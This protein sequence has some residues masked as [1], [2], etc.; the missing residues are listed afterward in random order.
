MKID[1]NL[2][3]TIASAVAEAVAVDR[4]G[5]IIKTQV[6]KAV[7]DA[8]QS[9]FNYHSP[10]RK[11]LEKSVAEMMPHALELD[12]QADW[13]H[14]VTHSINQRLSEVNDDRFKQ[15][16]LPVLDKLLEPAPASVKLSQLLKSI[17]DYWH[18]QEDYTGTP[19]M[20]IETSSVIS[21][22]YKEIYISKEKPRSMYQAEIQLRV[23]DE[24]VVWGVKLYEKDIEKQKFVG[25]LFNFEQ[26]LFQLY[27]CKTKIEFDVLSS[28]QVDFD[29]SSEDDED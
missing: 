5:T 14:F 9:A 24:G 25:P 21:S 2:E 23:K 13:N 28:D 26:E 10:F 7:D 4:I 3:E 22:V 18:D 11:V 27:A 20:H 16:I 6:Q 1:I 17:A 19:W 8:V 12:K 15:A 29:Y